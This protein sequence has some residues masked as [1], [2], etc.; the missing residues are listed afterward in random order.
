MLLL[1]ACPSASAPAPPGSLDPNFGVS[2]VVIAT[3][4]N[5]FFAASVI[6]LDAAGRIIVAGQ[7]W[8][9]T[10]GSMDAIIAWFPPDGTPD[11]SFGSGGLVVTDFDGGSDTFLGVSVDAAGR[12]VATGWGTVGGFNEFILA[13]YSDS[14]SLDLGFG[15]AGKVTTDFGSDGRVRTDFGSGYNRNRSVALDA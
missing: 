8:N 14:G 7:S 15:T 3:F 4:G 11:G 2:G 1:T 6:A 5:D 13:R 10:P 9:A 12:I